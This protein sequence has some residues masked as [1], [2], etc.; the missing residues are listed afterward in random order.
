MQSQSITTDVLLEK[1]AKNGEMSADDIYKR[2]SKGIASV[3]ANPDF[4]EKEFYQNMHAGAIG[5]GRIMSAAGTNVDATLMN[6]FVQPV[7]DCI[8]GNDAEGFPGIYEALRESAETM[9]RGGGVGYNF[10]KIRPKNAVVGK[11]GALASGPC[12]YMDIFDASC[13]TIE[14]A[15]S[16]RGAQMG[17][18]NIDHPDVEQFITA[19]RTEGRWNNFNVSVFVTDAFMAAKENNE[20]IELIHKAA[21]SEKLIAEGAYQ[22]EDGVWVYKK[23]NAND[24]WNKIMKSNYDFAEPGILFRDNMNSDNNLRYCEILEATNP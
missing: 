16:R 12:S 17:V 8:Q 20:S 4:W 9:R 24:L 10:S 14:S 23:V 15:G 3:E 1:Y 6:C 22:R 21:P 18:L 13:K 2:V 19:K 11:V 5:A 7:G